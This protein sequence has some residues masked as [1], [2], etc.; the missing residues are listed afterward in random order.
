M[1]QPGDTVQGTFFDVSR[2]LQEQ[3]DE[4]LLPMGP[5]LSIS[6]GV[7]DKIGR[8]VKRDG[9]T[10]LNPGGPQDLT[11]SDGFWR[12]GVFRNAP[13]WFAGTTRANAMFAYLAKPN[14]LA[15]TNNRIVGSGESAFRSY[16]ATNCQGS[17]TIAYGETANVD[18]LSTAWA[19]GIMAT[20][21]QATA[22]VF[23]V[24]FTDAA[25][26]AVLVDE[27]Y[28]GLRP[29][30]LGFE[31]DTT[32]DEW[33]IAI[34]YDDAD[35]LKFHQWKIT[36]ATWSTNAPT[37]SGT[38]QDMGGAANFDCSV[39]YASGTPNNKVLIAHHDLSNPVPTVKVYEWK[40]STPAPSPTV[41]SLDADQCLAWLVDRGGAGR[42]F[43][44]GAG[45][46]DGVVVVVMSTAFATILANRV[47]D[48]PAVIDVLNITGRSSSADT[49]GEFKIA[50]TIDAPGDAHDRIIKYG[51]WNQSG[52]Q[53]GEW[54]FGVELTSKMFD[55]R[56]SE[57][58]T[59]SF[60]IVGYDDDQDGGNFL[61]HF[62]MTENAVPVSR[63]PQA[64]FLQRKGGV[65]VLPQGLTEVPLMEKPAEVNT[66]G[67]WQHGA[68][69]ISK[70]RL[71]FV[72]AVGQTVQIG[73]DL[74]K[75]DFQP[76]KEIGQFPEIADLLV[77]P[78]SAARW[79]DGLIYSEFGFD[80]PP[81]LRSV[82]SSATA[83]SLV[84]GDKY[85]Y[86][87]VYSIRSDN[88]GRIWRSAPS[89]VTGS[90]TPSPEQTSLELTIQN[91]RITTHDENILQ[92]GL[93]YE[94]KI[95]I[96][97]TEG[98]GLNFKLI[99]TLSNDV[100]ANTQT[101]IDS[102]PDIDQA[103]GELLYTTGGVLE[104][105]P[106]PPMIGAV[107]W[108]GRMVCIHAEIRNQVWASKVIREGQSLG[109]SESLIIDMSDEIAL[110]GL[111]TFD[112]RLLLFSGD[113]VF[114]V[115]GDFPDDRGQ[116]QQPQAQRISAV[117]T[118]FP[119]SLVP[120]E[121]VWFITPKKQ[122]AQIDRGLQLIVHQEPDDVVSANIA[123]GDTYEAGKNHDDHV[124]LY[125]PT[126]N[127]IRFYFANGRFTW[128]DTARR[129]WTKGAFEDGP[130]QRDRV[131]DVVN[132]LGEAYV[133][134]PNSFPS[135][136]WREQS[137]ATKDGT[138][139][140]PFSVRFPWLALAGRFSEQRIHEIAFLIEKVGAFTA[141]ALLRYDYSETT[142]QTLTRD[143][144][145]VSVGPL[146]IPIKAARRRCASLSV[147]INDSSQDGK[148]FEL[149]GLSVGWQPVGRRKP[150]SS[151]NRLTTV[152]PGD[153]EVLFTNDTVVGNDADEL[154][155]DLHSHTLTAGQMATNGDVITAI[156]AIHHDDAAVN[157]T[158]RARVYWDGVVIWDSL[159]YFSRAGGMLNYT[160][161]STI[162]R[163]GAATQ[164][165][166]IVVTG[167]T[168]ADVSTTGG[169]TMASAIIVK[170]TGQI[171]VDES[172]PVANAVEC[173]YSSVEYCPVGG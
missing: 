3:V 76:N 45:T 29:R 57:K 80:M 64:R 61:M 103:F 30:V 94:C 112:D 36:G 160:V 79:F 129:V 39:E 10:N 135:Q 42:R 91:L 95:E 11:D 165:I 46:T 84:N 33:H 157:D 67:T 86:Q 138:L 20:V 21:W 88:T 131:G 113:A 146:N 32:D 9:H 73:A 58:N 31:S 139:K 140:I 115:T 121:G 161:T 69:L 18:Y 6:N 65:H 169:A 102:V 2:G 5:A 85:R 106:A 104:N 111:A 117:G 123:A 150:T 128:F 7:Y 22:Q 100:L 147:E 92:P 108:R 126:R 114:V 122:I 109:F 55:V 143:V 34:F 162:T 48:A 110:T 132:V 41:K 170:A 142:Q 141:Q 144:S 19:D 25:T 159:D 172:S 68:A 54:L 37:S 70:R 28:T 127:Q 78:Q 27:L 72:G 17:R 44:A 83:G 51:E 38:I 43:I 53:S 119:R 81:I 23:R 75:L 156:F 35:D 15:A 134:A 148:S 82:T 125:F 71:Q 97:R 89:V 63:A 60:V 101:Y 99:D 12:L 173:T 56:G 4:K 120:W 158:A 124:G 152:I 47:I 153:C 13:V 52:T 8:I 24:L 14:A 90:Y 98:N 151:N 74:F 130:L 167:L 149:S 116:G 164:D 171:T 154:E 168:G 77:V 1:A 93:G 50:Y 136:L 137:T 105:L 59:E 96:Y 66:A 145:A 163:T 16:V 118:E 26:G 107:E 155:K 49:D 40:I 87:I 166:E 133:I 62:D